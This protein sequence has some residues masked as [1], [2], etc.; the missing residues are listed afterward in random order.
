[1]TH[2]GRRLATLVTVGLLGPLAACGSGG[3]PKGVVGSSI[4]PLTAVEIPSALNGLALVPEDAHRTLSR[5]SRTYVRA[6]GLYSLR[7]NDLVEATLQVMQLDRTA[8]YRDEKF[9]QSVVSQIGGSNP[10]VLRVGD[11]TVYSTSISH[12]G[13]EIWF[14]GANLFVLSIRSDYAQ[15]RSLLR[16]ALGVAA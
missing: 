3:G 16:A 5:V 15:P 12:Q 7:Q 11:A 2:V 8:R 4:R 13:V 10:I 14:R 9:R 1:M 6:A